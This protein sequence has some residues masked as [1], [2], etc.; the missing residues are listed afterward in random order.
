MAGRFT[1]IYIHLVFAVKNRKAL[2]HPDWDDRLYKYI[3]GIVNAKGH[4]ALAIN[5][6]WDHIHIFLG[7]NPT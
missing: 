4:K 6:H 3:V 7:L 2:I 1:Q 5:G